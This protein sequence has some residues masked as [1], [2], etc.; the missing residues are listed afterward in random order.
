MSHKATPLATAALLQRLCH[1]GLVK[2]DHPIDQHGIQVHVILSWSSL[3]TT[4]LHNM[5]TLV[6]LHGK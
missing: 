1:C 5:D 6:Y 2:L 3:H 4:S